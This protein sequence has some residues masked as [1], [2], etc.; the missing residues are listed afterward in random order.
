MPDL[1]PDDFGTETVTPPV[2]ILREQ[3]EHLSRRTGG[4]VLATVRTKKVEDKFAHTFSLEVPSLDN[5][6]YDLFTI[7]HPITLY[8]VNFH[9][10]IV[11]NTAL[12]SV[13]SP[14]EFEELLRATFAHPEVSRIVA[15]LKAQ[16]VP[17]GAAP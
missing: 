7:Y 17:A 2:V 14:T 9:Q 3:A 5:Y 12:K 10:T 16:A 11:N 4:L 8:P 15:A 6:V 1:L 13:T